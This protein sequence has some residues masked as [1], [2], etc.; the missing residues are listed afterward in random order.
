MPTMKF[1]WPPL[2]IH[3]P[4]A[5]DACCEDRMTTLLP[6]ADAPSCRPCRPNLATQR[7]GV[8]GGLGVGHAY[9][10]QGQ[11]NL[12]PIAVVAALWMLGIRAQAV[13]IDGRDATLRD[14]AIAN[15]YPR[16]RSSP[17]AQ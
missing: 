6:T 14:A 12:C 10:H 5:P 15:K 9:V 7:I 1:F 8:G 3:P 13:V 4:N 2:Y 17:V 11:Q 16:E